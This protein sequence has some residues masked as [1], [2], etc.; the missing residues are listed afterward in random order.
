MTKTARLDEAVGGR[1]APVDRAAVLNRLEDEAARIGAIKAGGERPFG[2][3][4]EIV[5]CA[6]ARGAVAAFQ[7]REAV[8]TTE[9]KVRVVRSGHRGHDALRRADAFDLMMAKSRSGSSGKAK[10]PLFTLAQ[11][12]AGR[13][14]AAL[15]ERCASAGLK[16]S[17]IEAS[18]ASGTGGG[19]WIDAVLGDLQRLDGMRGRIGEEWAMRPSG[20]AA[21]ADR[22]HRS[23]RV[24]Q[25]VDMVCIG[26]MTLS[27]VLAAFGWSG[28]S[29]N[30]QRALASL[31]GALDRLH[32]Y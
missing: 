23:I 15:A 21:H 11:I 22:G 25:L 5:D 18:T 20:A 28:A 27:A 17:S 31:T 24:R 10:A 7:P 29:K 9:G 13:E 6:P 16:C 1:V 3:G 4:P 2:A 32:G 14:Y 19:V 8:L 12:I 30:R 26:G